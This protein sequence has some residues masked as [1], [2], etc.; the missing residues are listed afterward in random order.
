[1][2]LAL[3]MNRYLFFPNEIGVTADAAVVFA[4]IV[5][6]A[7]Q[8]PW[9]GPLLLALLVGPLDAR[10]WGARA[11]SRM[12]YN[13]GSTALTTA[14]GVAVFAPLATAFGPGWE[15]TL[16]AAALAAIPYVVVELT[17]GVG[18]VTLLG[19]R[20]GDAA[21][22]Q[23]PLVAIA[24]P[25]AVVGAGAGL[26]GL[27]LGWWSTIAVLL[28]VPVVPELA[29]VNLPRRTSRVTRLA[30]GGVALCLSALLIPAPFGALAALGGLALLVGAE[31]RIHPSSPFPVLTAPLAVAAVVIAPDGEA[32]LAVALV[33]TV[34]GASAWW[35]ASPT[36]A[37]DVVGRLAWTVPICT[38]SAF[39][40]GV[41]REVGGRLGT[42][43]YVSIAIATLAVVAAWGAPPWGSRF[44]G[45]WSRTHLERSRRRLVV[46]IW[47][48]TVALLVVGVA[49]PARWTALSLLA[50]SMCQGLLA[51][52]AVAVRQWRFAPRRRAWEA[53]L[54]ITLA[55]TSA[56][57]LALTDDSHAL[58]AGALLVTSAVATMIAWPLPPGAPS[59][60]TR[61]RTRTDS[62]TGAPYRLPE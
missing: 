43:A 62:D 31:C 54:V 12:A 38:A 20:P 46:A 49:A 36:G 55:A 1:V 57:V 15:A 42:L 11:W 30:V 39:A 26:L 33:V 28:P 44:I 47:S 23:L 5:A 21:R 6:F 9:L 8:S 22:H 50:A 34:A 24:L 48:F 14:A 10:H 27:D 29:F 58:W 52:A 51:I 16:G 37:R 19:E 3:C 40:A 25:L 61:T 7:D 45:R 59:S 13:S 4:A 17:L 53:A 56:V 2:P 35:V 60:R 18:L 32:M 41:W